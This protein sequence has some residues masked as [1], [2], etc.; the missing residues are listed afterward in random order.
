ML[1]RD[2]P[3]RDPAPLIRRVYAYVAYR[4]GDGPEAEDVTGEVFLRA[5]RYRHRFD[6]SK[7][8]PIAWLLG[9]ARNE[10]AD[11]GRDVTV[12]LDL[13]DEPWLEEDESDQVLDRLVLRQAVSRLPE[14]DRE[15]I[16]LRYG[17]DLSARQIADLTGMKPHAVDV[18]V[19]RAISRL[20]ASLA[21]S[22][23][24]V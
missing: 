15:L 22:E 17:S 20:R 23:S 2:D 3:L 4:V 5:A 7:G 21:S 13:T 1:R 14:R 6:A 11:R 10:L 12:S 16:A 9:I 8:Q 24:T 18:A 19:S